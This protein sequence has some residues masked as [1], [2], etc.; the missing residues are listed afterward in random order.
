MDN[1][2]LYLAVTALLTEHE[3]SV[4][5]LREFLSSLHVEF[6]PHFSER[7]LIPGDLL[8]ALRTAFVGEVPP[9]DPRWRDE[10]LARQPA[11]G[12]ERV[13]LML[14]SQVLD[15]EDAEA[16]GAASDEFRGFGLSVGRP[17]GAKRATDDYY[18]NWSPRGY[19]EC[20][21]VGA[22]GGWEPG[23]DTGRVLVPGDVAVLTDDG[24]RS[25]PAEDVERP[26]VELP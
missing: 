19:V 6:V 25:V 24:M 10:D 4:R 5:T 14:K 16:S 12:A 15:M 26:V 8:A 23:D 13:D 20:G 22:F 9:I 7:G 11:S 17:P 21:V 2:D 18:Y 1:R 3:D